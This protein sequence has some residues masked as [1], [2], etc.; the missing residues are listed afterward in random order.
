MSQLRK[1]VPKY[2]PVSWQSPPCNWYKVNTD[3]SFINPN[4]AGFGGL[5]RDSQVLFLGGFVFKVN[6]PSAIDVEVLGLLKLFE[7]LGF[8]VGL[9]YGWKLTLCWWFIIFSNPHMVPWRQRVPWL[10][11]LFL[12]RQ[13]HFFVSHIYREG[14]SLVDKLANFDAFNSSSIWWLTLP[15]FL[16]PLLW[17]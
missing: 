1:K 17:A 12:A 10:N 2:I 5:F 8:V 15:R 14:N 6:V 7:L 13:L 11:C 9:T 4:H 3:G 16:Y